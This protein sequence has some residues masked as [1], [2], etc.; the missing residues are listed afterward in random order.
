MRR[1]ALA[2]RPMLNSAPRKSWCAHEI[3]TRLVHADRGRDE[4]EAARIETDRAVQH[5]ERGFVAGG[6]NH[7][8]ERELR[9]ILNRTREA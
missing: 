2:S 8:V 7:G 9:P 5:A 6:Q 1:G 3:E 4:S